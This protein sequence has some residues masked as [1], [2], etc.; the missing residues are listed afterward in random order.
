MP[1]GTVS[2]Y[3]AEARSL[4]QDRL[5]PYRYS[6]ADLKTAL[7]LAL[8]E[9]RKYRPDLFPLGVVPSVEPATSPGTAI[10]VDTQYRLPLVY[11]MVA[12]VSMRD[13][14][15]GSDSRGTAYMRLFLTKLVIIG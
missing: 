3:M 8:Y 11:Y 6:D 15:E 2:D 13:E 9:A 4:L 5:T 1:L 12:H 14:E 7:G 10:A